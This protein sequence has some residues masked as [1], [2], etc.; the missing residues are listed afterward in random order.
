MAYQTNQ[1]ETKNIR[2]L[3]KTDPTL[4]KYKLRQNGH[5]SGTAY[6]WIQA[7]ATYPDGLI[8]DDEVWKERSR[9]KWLIQNAVGRG[10]LE[11]DIQTDYFCVN[12]SFDLQSESELSADG[13]RFSSCKSFFFSF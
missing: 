6:S 8:Q 9:I 3:F 11:D 13:V 12:I 1:E 7:I 4:Q 2:Q 10:D 5:G